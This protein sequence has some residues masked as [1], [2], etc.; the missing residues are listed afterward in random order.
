MQQPK[1]SAKGH[2]V[3][4]A[5]GTLDY[6]KIDISEFVFAFLE[7][8]QQQQQSQH[9]HLLQFLQLLMEKAMNYS[10]LSVRNFNLSINQ[11]G[12]P[13]VKWMSFKLDRIL[14]FT[15]MLIFVP[16]RIQAPSFQ[17][18]ASNVT[19][20]GESRKI[21]IVLTGI[22]S[23]NALVTSLT[24]S[25]RTC[26]TAEYVLLISIPCSIVLNGDIC[27]AKATMTS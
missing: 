22:I 20:L 3:F 24:Q 13:G 4:S 14:S 1:A 27:S 25:T 23:P 2:T 19:P 7:F 9:Q 16:V 6:D 8:V 11:V 10:W 21:C 5:K 26:I 12:L 15:V 18:H 17:V